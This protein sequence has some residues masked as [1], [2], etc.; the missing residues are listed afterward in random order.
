MRSIC[1][2]SLLLALLLLCFLSLNTVGASS[3]ASIFRFR[4]FGRHSKPTSRRLYHSNPNPD[5]DLDDL[6]D[7]ITTEE[8][9]QVLN[10]LIASDGG[11]VLN[12]YVPS[13]RW[14][15][16]QWSDSV[17]AQSVPRAAWNMWGTA[18]LCV[19]L[20]LI[21][22]GELDFAQMPGAMK[23]SPPLYMPVLLEICQ[24]VNVIW[25]SMSTLTTFLLL[26]F[27]SQSFSFWR[28]IHEVARGI[29]GH[30]D[31]LHLLLVTHVSRRR[32]PGSYSVDAE[33]FLQDLT[34]KL[35]AYHICVWATH[36]RR[37]R[38][39]LT[40]KGI[41][42]M[43]AKG[44]LTINEKEALDRQLG[45]PRDQ[46]HYILLEWILFNCKEARR[47]RI[48]DGGGG[49]EQAILSKFCAL[50]DC[51]AQM[52]AK[53]STRMP[54]PYIHLVQ[55]LLDL[56]LTMAPLAQF[57]ELGIFTVLSSGV[58][59][60]FYSALFSLATIFLDPFD[61]EGD[62]R[63]GYALMDLAVLV[64]ESNLSSNLLLKAASILKWRDTARRR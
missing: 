59:T 61:N 2:P 3:F 15:Y 6:E 11:L 60:L 31:D 4:H 64:R 25:K 43:V 21:L 41:S 54:L 52:K 55:I 26:F 23:T 44:I 37:F 19:L 36:A 8:I 32:G 28:S 46:K 47:R 22:Y 39:L 35:R 50:R 42:R 13:R 57:S 34:S 49:M 45:V 10:E 30:I 63:D 48:V 7:S 14:L 27:V 24:C 9:D 62:F 29:Q 1:R 38:I 58:L 33:L 12:P 56:F 5:P 20:R 51:S 53:I 40:D 16:Q 17:L 18:F